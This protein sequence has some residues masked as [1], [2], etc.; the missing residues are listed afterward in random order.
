MVWLENFASRSLGEMAIL[1]KILTNLYYG[2]EV[3]WS[4]WHGCSTGGRQ[5][6]MVAQKFPGSFDGVLAVAPAI[7]WSMFVVGEVWSQV[8]MNALGYW[9]ERCEL[10]FVTEEAVR[11]CDGLDGVADGIVGAPGLCGYD[12]MSVVGRV[13]DCEGEERTVSREAAEIV[14][15]AWKGPVDGDGK[16]LWFG[17]LLHLVRESTRGAATKHN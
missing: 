2:E 6:M 5:G 10:E 12:A 1:G 11:E 15:A 13:F 8:V 17:K 4:Y 16:A 3:K 14:N 9:P 7:N